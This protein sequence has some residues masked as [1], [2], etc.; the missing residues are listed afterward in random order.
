MRLLF[1]YNIV[2]G[3]LLFMFS[4]NSCKSTHQSPYDFKGE[5]IIFGSG[6]GFSGKVTEY[7][8]LSNGEFY[9]GTNTDQVYAFKHKQNARVEQIFNSYKELNFGNLDINR[10]GNIYNFIVRYKEGEA[11]HKIQWGDYDTE[12]PES[13]RIYF[14]NLMAFAKEMNKSANNN[15][16]VK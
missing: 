5:K 16:P 9:K 6:G 10:S 8:L 2:T 13:L 11:S 7:T 14:K 4:L 15:M 3:L 1:N 12:V